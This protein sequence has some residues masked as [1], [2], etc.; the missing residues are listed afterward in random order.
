MAIQYIDKER[1][2]TVI[3]PC[4]CASSSFSKI[5]R[6]VGLHISPIVDWSFRDSKKIYLL[7]RNPE[8]WYKSGYKFTFTEGFQ[9]V[10]QGFIVPNFDQHIDLVTK[11]TKE[12][13]KHRDKVKATEAIGNV[14]EQ[15]INHCCISPN[16]IYYFWCYGNSM[17]NKVEFVN[18]DNDKQHKRLLRMINPNI[19]KL[20]REN[21][22]Q[23]SMYIP[24]VHR[25]LNKLLKMV[26]LPRRV[27][28]SI[29]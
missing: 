11:W 15:W 2:F 20:R 13:K 17:R 21:V 22:N 29:K 3:A 28:R 5:L 25:G 1:D 7:Y 6:K 10:S 4:K 23:L 9:K 27:Q 12:Y 19:R 26:A 18:I 8:Q 16:F 24:E 14:T